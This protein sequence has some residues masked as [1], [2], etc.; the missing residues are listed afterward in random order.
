MIEMVL[1]LGWV[2][3]ICLFLICLFLLIHFVYDSSFSYMSGRK[4]RKNG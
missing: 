4:L 1:G 3:F 2:L